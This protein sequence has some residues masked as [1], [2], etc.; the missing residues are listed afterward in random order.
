[1]TYFFETYG[2]QMMSRKQV[3]SGEPLSAQSLREAQSRAKRRENTNT[4]SDHME[5]NK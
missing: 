4:N 2:C 5:A 1:M 3:R